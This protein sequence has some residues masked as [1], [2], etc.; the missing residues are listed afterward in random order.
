MELNRR[1][2]AILK[3]ILKEYEDYCLS[4]SFEYDREEKE[5]QYKINRALITLNQ[6]A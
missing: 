5:L 4:S 2:L 6:E 3:D 1:E